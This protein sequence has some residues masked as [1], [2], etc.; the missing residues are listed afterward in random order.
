MIQA[1]PDDRKAIAVI[2]TG[3]VGSCTVLKLASG[4]PKVIMIDKDKVTRDNLM[5]ELDG[6]YPGYGLAQHKGY[7]TKKHLACLNSLGPCP[8]HRKSFRPVRDITR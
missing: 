7:G 2:G 1:A 6:K 4:L 8:I 3:I 5:V